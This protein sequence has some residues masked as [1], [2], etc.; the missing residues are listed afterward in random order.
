MCVL[1]SWWHLYMQIVAFPEL[2]CDSWH[3]CLSVQPLTNWFSTNL[4]PFERQNT[5]IAKPKLNWSRWNICTLWCSCSNYSGMLTPFAQGKTHQSQCPN[6][7]NQ[8][9]TYSESWQIF[10]CF[11]LLVQ[12]DFPPLS[13]GSLTPF[14]IFISICICSV[15][16]TLIC[17]N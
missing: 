1:I 17:T 6:S 16:H 14:T 8:G 13:F 12:T 7:I 5:S 4:T 15:K 2:Q 9:E 3:V 10:A 11:D